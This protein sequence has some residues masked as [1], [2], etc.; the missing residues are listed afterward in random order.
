MNIDRAVR[1]ERWFALQFREMPG[2]YEG[3]CNWPG[4]PIK[5]AV[6]GMISAGTRRMPLGAALW[7]CSNNDRSDLLRSLADLVDGQDGSGDFLRLTRKDLFDS[8]HLAETVDRALE[9]G[10]LTSAELH[11]IQREV[12]QNLQNA[13]EIAARFAR[14]KTGPIED[15]GSDA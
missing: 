13:T 9:D 6:L 7:L 1:W 3:A 8:A 5:P 15:G 2:G 4:S 10:R 14:L 11:E 12:S